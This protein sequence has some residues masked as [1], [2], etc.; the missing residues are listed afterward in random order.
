[1][2]SFFIVGCAT[3][4]VPSDINEKIAYGYASAAA[5]ANTATYMLQTKKISKSQGVAI[6]NMLTEVDSYL[7]K[8]KEY[9]DL[10][11]PTEAGKQLD[12]AMFI[13][14]KIE[15]KLKESEEKDGIP[16]LGYIT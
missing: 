15:E 10:K 6:Y 9:N 4:T 5:V 16:V 11:L 7:S 14:N 13:L 1:M 12:L 2:C 3:L 8:A